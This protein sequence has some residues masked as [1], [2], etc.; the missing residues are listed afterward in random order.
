MFGISFF[1]WS[2]ASKCKKLIIKARCTLRLLKWKRQSISTQLREEIALL[3]NNG[4][5]H[6]T[7]VTLVE[8]LIQGERLVAAYDLIDQFLEFILNKLSYIRK[9]RDCPPGINE[10]VSSLIFAS[11]RC[12][13]FP[14]LRLIRKLFQHRYGKNFAT[15]AVELLPRNLVNK[16]LIENLSLSVKPVPD[17]MKCR[18]VD[19][20]HNSLQPKVEDCKEYQF[21]ESDDQIND[22]IAGSKIHST[23]GEEI[24]RDVTKSSD[25]F[26]FPQSTLSDSS[27][28]VS[29]VQHYPPPK[30]VEKVDDSFDEPSFEANA[31]EM[32]EYVNVIDDECEEFLRDQDESTSN[33]LMKRSST[34]RILRRRSALPER[35]DTL[36]TEYRM[37]Y[38]KPRREHSSQMHHHTHYR[39]HLVEGTSQSSSYP[40]KRLK[41]HAAS[42]KEN[43]CILSPC[44]QGGRK[45]KGKLLH[46][47]I[48]CECSL[49]Q[50]CYCCVYND[51]GC[52]EAWSVK[53]QMKIKST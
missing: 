41:Q 29:T 19:E 40:Q 7:A 34:K 39:Q 30:T 21:V 33:K 38:G 35:H 17:G 13:G 11:A 46:T 48:M 37:Y 6:E 51:Q 32:V 47:L 36:E 31:E 14:E 26:S 2:K 23:K 16:K 18:V 42:E 1:G 28:L 53:P 27:A 8:E 10:A 5:H 25:V 52:W 12:A 43:Y 3:F 49:D 44:G 4:H 15:V 20:I 24:D 22:T 50:P 45:G 9:Q